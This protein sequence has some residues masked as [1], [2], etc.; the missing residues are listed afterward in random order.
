[1]HKHI[2]LSSATS[3]PE[4]LPTKMAETMASHQSQAKPYNHNLY[5]TFHKHSKILL[6]VMNTTQTMVVCILYSYGKFAKMLNLVT[7]SVK[8]MKYFAT[9]G[10]PCQPPAIVC[11]QKKGL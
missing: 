9:F 4:F 1:M 7:Y 5:T 10:R 11:K 2:D 8:K 6:N 3:Q